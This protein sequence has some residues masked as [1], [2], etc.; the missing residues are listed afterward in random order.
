MKVSKKLI[1]WC[2]ILVIV[3]VQAPHLAWVFQAMSSLGGWMAITHGILFA[4]AIDA[5]VLLFAVR[6]REWW[7][8]IFMMIS[9]IV[10]LQYYREFIDFNSDWLQAIS[11]LLIGASGVLAVYYLSKEINKLDQ[12]EK[13]ESEL[14]AEEDIQKRITA[15][16]LEIA[17]QWADDK[18]KWESETGVLFT[19][20][21]IEIVKMLKNEKTHNDIVEHFKSTDRAIS[22][23][24]IGKI[25]KKFKSLYNG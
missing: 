18:K 5:C 4:I 7:T 6:G 21:D 16:E 9:Y 13:H 11:T 2:A 25:A 19:D 14:N 8:A 15:K 22:K 12:Q 23:D 20:E 10:T 3:F 1:I 17:K 24:R